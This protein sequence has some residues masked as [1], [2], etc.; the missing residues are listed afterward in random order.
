MRKITA[1]TDDKTGAKRMRKREVAAR[2]GAEP[3]R[4]RQRERE[5]R[6][7]IADF[8]ASDRLD[9]DRLHERGV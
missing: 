5:L 1:S 7:R 8:R 4:A 2:G 3:A 6:A 9:C